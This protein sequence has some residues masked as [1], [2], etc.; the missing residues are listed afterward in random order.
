M[1]NLQTTEQAVSGPLFRAVVALLVGR[2]D[3]AVAAVGR[4]ACTAASS[5][6]SCCRGC[7]RR[8]ASGPFLI[9]VA[10]VGRQDAAR[11]A[12]AVVAVVVGRAVVALLGARSST[13]SPQMPGRRQA[14]VQVGIVRRPS[15]RTA[16][17]TASWTTPSP[18]RGREAAVGQRHR[19]IAAGAVAAVVG[20]VVALL[21]RALRP[22]RRRSSRRAGTARCSRCSGRRWRRCRTAR[23]IR[24]ARRMSPQRA[25]SLQ[26]GP[27][28]V[29]AP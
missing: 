17:R 9:A 5:R 14:G 21:L 28:P 20:A 3:H 4:P 13:P 10:A 27:Q 6:R 15:A 8:T 11:R 16:R 22:C 19:R 25:G 1:L 29:F 23:R 7:R 2:R 12:A 18:Q 26:P 24:S